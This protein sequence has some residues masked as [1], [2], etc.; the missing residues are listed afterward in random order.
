M[1][2]NA[3]RRYAT[4]LPALAG[5]LQASVPLSPL[6]TE[7]GPRTCTSSYLDQRR[8]S[9]RDTAQPGWTAGRRD[10]L[11]ADQVRTIYRNLLQEAERQGLKGVTQRVFLDRL[12]TEAEAVFRR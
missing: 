7:A 3:R 4:M 5:R 12:H 9:A 10:P 11:H 6:R 2:S 1:T 8:K